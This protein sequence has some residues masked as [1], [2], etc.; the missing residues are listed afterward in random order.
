M[1]DTQSTLH[2]CAEQDC[3]VASLG[4]VGLLG[5]WGDSLINWSPFLCCD[6]AAMTKQ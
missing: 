3:R 2:R 4:T 6:L 5:E 1:C